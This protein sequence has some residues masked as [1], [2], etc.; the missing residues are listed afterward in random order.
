MHSR[1]ARWLRW[2]GLFGALAVSLAAAI[3]VSPGQAQDSFDEPPPSASHT[4]PNVIVE[5]TSGI[6][7]A[8]GANVTITGTAAEIEAAG[9]N[10][11]V[12]ADVT[13]DVQLAGAVVRQQGTVGGKVQIGGAQVETRGAVTGSL[14]AAGATVWIGSTVGGNARAGG[15]NV[16]FSPASTVSGDLKAGAA[17]LIV[18]GT[19]A[20]DAS[21]AGAVVTISG[22][23]DGSVEVRA[24]QVIV[25]SGAVIGGDLTVYS[26]TDPEIREGATIGGEVRHLAPPEWWPRVSWWWWLVAAGA[27]ALGTVLAGIVLILF[28]GRAFA[29]ATTNVRHRPL[30]SFLYGILTLVLIPFVAIVLFATVVGISVGFAVLLTLPFLIVFGHA[31]AAA[32]IA[33]GILLRRPGDMSIGVSLVMLVI[34]SILLVALGLIPFV[35]P[36]LLGIVIVLGTGAFTRTV[37][38]R[39]RRPAPPPTPA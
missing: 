33:G 34:G 24:A 9:A 30:S 26:L 29:A 14:H 19:V 38:A 37:A 13:G 5:A 27:V 10:V 28:G 31:V 11:T 2:R 17:N 35:G 16:T 21:L 8:A 36:L 32:G 18:A 1:A 25:T 39:L 6:I 23:I 4:G 7:Q 12:R 20:G 3:A 22:R 15:A